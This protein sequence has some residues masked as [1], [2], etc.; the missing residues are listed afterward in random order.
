MKKR[1]TFAKRLPLGEG[2]K[3]HEVKRVSESSCVSPKYKLQYRINVMSVKIMTKMLVLELLAVGS[4]VLTILGSK[5]IIE[6]AN[7]KRQFGWFIFI[8]F[9]LV[10]IVAVITGKLEIVTAIFGTAI[11]GLCSMFWGRNFS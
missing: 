10:L 6:Q 9:M 4:L 1:T 5:A 7:T 3:G 11:F 2:H 8:A